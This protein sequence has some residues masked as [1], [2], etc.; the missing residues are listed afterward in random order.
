MISK[1]LLFDLSLLKLIYSLFLFFL[2][3]RQIINIEIYEVPK[4]QELTKDIF[5][6]CLNHKLTGKFICSAKNSL[7]IKKFML[8]KKH[9]E[10]LSPF[11][12]QESRDVVDDTY[13]VNYNKFN[14]EIVH[15]IFT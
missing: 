13:P 4:L 3:Y 7:G 9:L 8:H 15:S 10:L 6:T 14:D 2:H 11:N 1:Y 12:S 5:I